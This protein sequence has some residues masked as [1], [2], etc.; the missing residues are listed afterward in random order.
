MVRRNCLVAPGESARS[1]KIVPFGPS[2][3]VWARVASL[4]S[5]PRAH[6]R[7]Y[8]PETAWK[9]YRSC[10]GAVVC[11]PCATNGA[12]ARQRMRLRGC[13][14]AH[15]RAGHLSRQAHSQSP[16]ATSWRHSRA[17]KECF[18]EVVAT[19][20]ETLANDLTEAGLIKSALG[21]WLKASQR[22]IERSAY[23]EAL[24]ILSED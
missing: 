7:C 24:T 5:T 20:P 18:P 1:R 19:E 2:P 13:H 16:P 9:R 22:A 17:P 11:R 8:I 21:C 6:T 14:F 10:C 3:V 4:R 15:A 23:K 12:R